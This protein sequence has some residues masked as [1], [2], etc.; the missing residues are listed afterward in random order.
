MFGTSSKPARRDQ[1]LTSDS[2][3]EVEA[4]AAPSGGGP[5][6]FASELAKKI[7]KPAPVSQGWFIV[8]SGPKIFTF[9]SRMYFV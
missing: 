6:D 4:V 8:F 1:T 9:H 7:G 2:D 5:V 3:S